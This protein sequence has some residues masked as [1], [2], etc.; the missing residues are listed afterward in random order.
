MVRAGPDLVG[1]ARDPAILSGP[2][3]RVLDRAPVVGRCDARLPS[4]QRP[5]P[6]GVVLSAGLGFAAAAGRKEGTASL[7]PDR[8]SRREYRR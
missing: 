1:P 3:Q 2:A 5:V 4:G 6:R 7:R 8:E